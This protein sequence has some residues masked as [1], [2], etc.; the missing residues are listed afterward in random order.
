VRQA[1]L[2]V[3]DQGKGVDTQDAGKIFEPF[4]RS[5]ASRQVAGVGLGLAIAQQFVLAMRGELTLVSSAAGA[6]FRV[7]LPID[8]PY[9]RV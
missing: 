8:A 1:S 6:H 5:A 3:I 7:L 2:D 4:Y 9:L